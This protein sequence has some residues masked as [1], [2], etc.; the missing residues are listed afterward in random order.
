MTSAHT[1][2]STRI[3]HAAWCRKT[4]SWYPQ[5]D[6]YQPGGG[7][8][9]VRMEPVGGCDGGCF[10]FTTLDHTCLFFS[11]TR[12]LWHRHTHTATTTP[13]IELAERCRKTESCVVPNTDTQCP[14]T[15]THG[16]N[17]RDGCRNGT[18]W[19]WWRLAF[20]VFFQIQGKCWTKN[21]S[22]QREKSS[23]ENEKLPR[24]TFNNN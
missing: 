19:R 17:K 14:K 11:D 24:C 4:E 8:T 2:A 18:R 21:H 23:H 1:A 9:G 13:R 20:V 10:P 3:E 6:K 22:R 12:F 16:S 7:L 5:R 15:D